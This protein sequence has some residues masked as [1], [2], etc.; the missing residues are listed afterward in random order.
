MNISQGLRLVSVACILSLVTVLFVIDCKMARLQTGIQPSNATPKTTLTLVDGIKGP[1]T[2]YVSFGADSQIKTWD[3]CGE[4]SPCQ[5]TLVESMNLPLNGKY[6]NATFAFDHTVS[7]GATK[8]EVNVNNPKWYDVTDISLV[9][10]FNVPITMTVH[11]DSKEG[12]SDA[13]VVMSVTQEGGNE[14]T[15]GVFPDQCDVCTARMN[16]PC[17]MKPGREGCKA[18]SQYKPDVPCQYQ[19]PTVGGGSQVVIEAW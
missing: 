11:D 4:S 3:V 5:F 2:V 15:F 16:P 14:K 17:G 9:D 1:I 19:G 7:C 8:A 6:L 18:G 12:R 13:G 10:G